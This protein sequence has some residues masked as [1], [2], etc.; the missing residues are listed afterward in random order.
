MY[1]FEYVRPTS[2]EEAAKVLGEHEDAKLLAGGQSYLPTLKLRL[3]Q[4]DVL[5]DLSAVGG[6]V[7]GISRDGNSL[8]IGAL[9]THAEVAASDEVKSAIPALA[10]L[11][12]GIGDAQVRNRGTLG[13]SIANNDPGADYPAALVGLGAT[14]RTTKREIA[15]DDFFTGMFETALEDDEIVKAVSFPIPEKAGYAKFPNPASR[16]CLVSV[17]VAKTAGG[18][19]VAVSGAGPCVFRVDA[20]EQALGGNFSAAA[21]DGVS[22]SADDLN[23]DLY[24]TPEYRAHLVGVMAKR[25]VDAA[26]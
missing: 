23:N 6:D 7:K 1:A 20:M 26:G 2:L 24:G 4:P 11:A 9:T 17:M 16:Y 14:V 3:A 12:S 19:R 13:G 22:V 18:V 21:L 25:A 5:V 10:S 8:V 15:A